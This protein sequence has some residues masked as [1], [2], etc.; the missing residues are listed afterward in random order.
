MN[1]IMMKTYSV[2][3]TDFFFQKGGDLDTILYIHQCS[4]FFSDSPGLVMLFCS[5]LFVMVRCFMVL[6]Y[7]PF[8]LSWLLCIY[9]SCSFLPF[10]FFLSSLLPHLASTCPL[11]SS[12]ALSCPFALHC[13]SCLI[14]S[15]L[16]LPCP[17]CF[18]CLAC[19]R[20]VFP[21][22]ASPCI[23]FSC[24]TLP[25]LPSS[26]IV[27]PHL[28]LFYPASPCL[29]LSSFT[30]SYLRCPVFLRPASPCLIFH[31][32]TLLCL[33]SSIALSHLVLPSFIPPPFAL[34]CLVLLR[35]ASPPPLPPRS[36]LMWMYVSG[37]T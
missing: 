15:C 14:S 5:P 37:G 22:L 20:P 17:S 24:F 7:W 36:R 1:V 9:I 10:S 26:P 2:T 31:C 27:L 6:Y 29:I 8:V 21:R 18:T 16:V 13:L 33:P 3:Y 34:S 11:L 19:P 12:F 23:N 25:C 28:A 32:F 4:L 35:L 30:L